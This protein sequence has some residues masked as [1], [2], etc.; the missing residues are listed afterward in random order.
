MPLVAQVA[1][2]LVIG[3]PLLALAVYVFAR[4]AALGVYKSRETFKPT[5]KRR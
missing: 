4:V 3:I 5:P 2:G 1:I